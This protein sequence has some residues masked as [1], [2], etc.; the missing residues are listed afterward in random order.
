MTVA[1]ESAR[2]LTELFANIRRRQAGK[3]F[4]VRIHARYK[5]LA[6]IS[7]IENNAADQEELACRISGQR[8][9]YERGLLSRCSCLDAKI[10]EARM[11][12]SVRFETCPVIRS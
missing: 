2:N 1:I 8:R 4:A 10:L 11:L 7:V 5:N 12:L 6:D 9:M 3:G